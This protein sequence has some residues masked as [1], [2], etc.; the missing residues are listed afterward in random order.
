MEI[1]ERLI[2]IRKDAGKTQKEFAEA[3]EM[4][5][6]N[7]K[8]YEYG[9]ATISAPIIKLICVTYGVNQRWLETGEGDPYIPRENND[10]AQEV[11]DI[12]KGMPE[13]QVSVMASLAAMPEEW[14]SMWK[15][16]LEKEIDTLKKGR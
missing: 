4:T 15:K 8:N 5:R 6:E 16:Q 1:N 11:R 14:W 12:L 7:Y 3:M 9:R 13:F 2:K 10:L